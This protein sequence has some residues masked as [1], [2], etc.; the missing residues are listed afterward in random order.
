MQIIREYT[1][2]Y[3]THIKKVIA[4][5]FFF[6]LRN[7]ITDNNKRSEI[8]QRLKISLDTGTNKKPSMDDPAHLC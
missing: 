1:V 3:T 6:I 7:K 4:K 8:S 2:I 5:R